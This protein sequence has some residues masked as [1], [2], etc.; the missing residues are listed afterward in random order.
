M[1]ASQ[2]GSRI[3]NGKSGGKQPSPDSYRDDRKQ[4]KCS[5]ETSGATHPT[6]PANDE[7]ERLDMP[8]WMSIGAWRGYLEINHY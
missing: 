3:I 5:T 8:T 6:T 2:C 7:P 4:A 1:E